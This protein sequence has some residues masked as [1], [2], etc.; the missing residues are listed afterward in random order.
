MLLSR[1]SRRTAV[2]T[3]GAGSVAENRALWFK[4]LGSE[5]AA[6]DTTDFGDT[7]LGLQGMAKERQHEDKLQIR[8]SFTNRR[9]GL[10]FR[11]PSCH[12]AG[13]HRLRTRPV[14]VSGR[15]RL[16][17]GCRG[18]TAPRAGYSLSGKSD[19]KRRQSPWVLE[20]RR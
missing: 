16:E 20:D 12:R 8:D 15:G 18:G 6:W 2:K 1:P 14:D 11:G 7:L 3:G 9:T 10:V 13:L 5:Q 4:R 19:E 17:N